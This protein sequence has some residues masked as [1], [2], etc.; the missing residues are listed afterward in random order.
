[1]IQ[2]KKMQSGQAVIEYI[3]LLAI[4][5]G[6]FVAVFTRLAQ[7]NVFAAMKAPLEKDFMYTYRY[8]HPQARGQTDGG[9]KY[10]PQ[11]PSDQNFRIFINPPISN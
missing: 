7:T 4:V 10:I 8:G 2:T 1:M 3:L 9:P 6:L 5:V 11:D